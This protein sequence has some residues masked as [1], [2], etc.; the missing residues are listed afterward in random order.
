MSL[1]F[2]IIVVKKSL[3]KGSH[4]YNIVLNYLEFGELR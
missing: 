1:R 4:F 3:R 2:V